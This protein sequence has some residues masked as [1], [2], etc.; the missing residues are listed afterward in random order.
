MNNL[1]K[2]PSENAVIYLVCF[3]VTYKILSQLLLSLKLKLRPFAAFILMAPKKEL[4]KATVD[5]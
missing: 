5:H 3:F 2:L 4:Q 1:F